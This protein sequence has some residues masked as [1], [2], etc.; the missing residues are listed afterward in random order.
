MNEKDL[1]RA[2]RLTKIIRRPVQKIFTFWDTEFEY[3]IVS[4]GEQGSVLRH[5]KLVCQKPVIITPETLRENFSGF[6]PEALKLFERD[7]PELFQRLR[8]MGYQVTNSLRQR[9]EYSLEVDVLL[10]R[11]RSQMPAENPQLALLLTPDDLWMFGILKLTAEVIRK[12]AP[13]NYRDF[14]E[15]GYFRTEEERQREEI[16]ILFAEARENPNY[17]KELGDTLQRYGL[18]E[19]YEDR[20]FSLLKY[21][22]NL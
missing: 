15:R 21:L 6:S 22:R 18:F 13:G 11:V 9:E 7:H 5:G 2:L 16:E 10:E 14:D 20:F 12:S 4:A 17:I 1:I 8:G 3:T 19:Q